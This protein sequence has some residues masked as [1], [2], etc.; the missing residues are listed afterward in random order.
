M[1]AEKAIEIL[2]KLISI[3][4]FSRNESEAADGLQA[5]IEK[6]GYAVDRQDKNLVVR[7]KHWADAKPVLL[8]NSHIDTVKPSDKWTKDPFTPV[9]ENG[10]LY[11]LGS[12]DAGASVVSLLISFMILD[13]KEQPY[14]L[15]Y[16]ASV[17]EEISGLNGIASLIEYLPKVDF[18]VVGEPTQMHM[19]TAEKGLMVLDCTAMGKSG[20]AARKE[21]LNAIYEALPDIEWFRTHEF[22]RVSEFLGEVKMTVTQ[23][24]AGRQHN[25]VPDKCTFVVDIRSNELYSNEELHEIIQSHVKCDVAPRSYRLNSSSTPMDHPAVVKGQQ[26]GRQT[27]GSPTTSDQAVLPYYS[28]KMGPGDSARSHT[29]DEYILLDEIREGV[30]IYCELFDGLEIGK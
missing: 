11:G 27:Y 1:N 6:L 13:Q 22:S 25:V 20:H 5:E 2:K 24:E 16:V 30:K 19:A 29:A 28:V 26:M 8:F 7:S 21:G 17:E 14:N 3:E 9:V 23:I 18:A 10:I 15:I 12:N 4:S